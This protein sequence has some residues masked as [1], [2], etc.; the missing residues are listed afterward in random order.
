ME[1]KVLMDPSGTR[2]V[3]LPGILFA[4]KRN[5]DWDSVE[6]YLQRYVGTSVRIE[7]FG[8]VIHIGP[9]FVDEYCG[10]DY[11]KKLMGARA[12]A[13]AN[14]VQGICELLQIA[15]DRKHSENRK[16]KHAGD[17]R[18]GWYYYTTRFALRVYRDGI[19]S[20]EINIYS[21]C[22]IVNKAKDG[23]MYLYDMVDIKKETSTPLTIYER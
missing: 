15:Y 22:M 3:L 6:K 9:R 14:A 5:I 18:G 12:R 16:E 23:R 17:A 21:A 19:D 13:K 7:R 4:G 10:S 1:P 20:K 2:F 8:D 11:T